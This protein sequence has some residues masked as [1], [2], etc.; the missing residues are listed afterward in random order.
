ME[1]CHS[2]I[3][4]RL[5]YN[6]RSAELVA[7]YNHLNILDRMQDIWNPLQPFTPA[8]LEVVWIEQQIAEREGWLNMPAYFRERATGRIAFLFY[9]SLKGLLFGYY[10]WLVHGGVRVVPPSHSEVTGKRYLA[11]RYRCSFFGAARSRDGTINEHGR[12]IV[13]VTESRAKSP[14]I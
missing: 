12:V 13:A 5:A 3:Y 1:K 6:T 8:N 2:Q 14:W 4:F 9:G 7:R 11:R 10:Q